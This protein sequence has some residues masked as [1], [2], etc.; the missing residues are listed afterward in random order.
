MPCQNDL[1]KSTS[2]VPFLQLPLMKYFQEAIQLELRY[3]FMDKTHALTCRSACS[4]VPPGELPRC[5]R[6]ALLT[7]WYNV[8]QDSKSRAYQ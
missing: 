1:V 2:R 8:T 6:E 7:D 5:G 3:T 4:D